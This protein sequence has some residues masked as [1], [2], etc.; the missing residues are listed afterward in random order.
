MVQEID[1]SHL[2]AGADTY[3]LLIPTGD[4]THSGAAGDGSIDLY[5]QYLSERGVNALAAEQLNAINSSAT[6]GVQPCEQWGVHPSM[7]KLAE[8]YVT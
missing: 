1:S 2:A 8:S 3:N 5:A 7:A 6:P 4:C